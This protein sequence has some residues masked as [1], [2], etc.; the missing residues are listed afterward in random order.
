[1]ASEILKRFLLNDIVDI[2]TDYNLPEKKQIY[3]N[4][5]KVISNLFLVNHVHQNIP[6]MPEKM[7]IRVAQCSAFCVET[8]KFIRKNMHHFPH[9]HKPNFYKLKDLF[10]DGIYKKMLRLLKRF[11]G[12]RDVIRYENTPEYIYLLQYTKSV[13]EITKKKQEAY[14]TGKCIAINKNNR[15]KCCYKRKYEFYCGK[16][17]NA[18]DRLDIFDVFNDI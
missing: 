1:M 5:E 18:R 4:S 15:K 7:V 2:I 17:Q 16:H 10:N 9:T 6:D 11:K 13:L 12:F 14:N 3:N 8:N